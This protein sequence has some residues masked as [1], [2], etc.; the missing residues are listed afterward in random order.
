MKIYTKTGDNGATGLY[1]GERVPKTHPKIEA[2]GNVDELTSHLGDIRSTLQKGPI[3]NEIEIIQKTLILVM[4]EIAST[5]NGKWKEKQ[6]S[7]S[8]L[9]NSIDYY[10]GLAGEFTKFILP[11]DNPIS[12]KFDIARSVARRAERAVNRC[13]NIES[14]VRQYINRLSDYLYVVA[15]YIDKVFE[16]TMKTK[17]QTTTQEL[18]LNLA[19]QIINEVKEYAA[20]KGIQVV[21]AVVSKEGNPISVQ[22]MD[23]SFVISYELA[24]KKAFTAAA[25]KMPTHELAKLT[26][27]GADF[28]GLENMLDAKIV[29]LGGGYPIKVNGLVIGAVGVSGGSA[30]DDIEFARYGAHFIEGE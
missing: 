20:Y 26:A 16:E 22:V 21:I 24:I 30:T 7:V 6:A 2:V 27:R 15:R 25:L 18:D 17:K 12:A 4:S 3:V 13:D 19:N 14:E 1:S 5:A 10:Q 8:F 23:N 11:G 9:E 28:E 29:T